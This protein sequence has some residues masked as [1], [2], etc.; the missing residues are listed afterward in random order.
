MQVFLL[1]EGSTLIMHK[2]MVSPRGQFN[3]DALSA[4]VTLNTHCHHL[5]NDERAVHL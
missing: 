1:P 3:Y 2:E 4:K 5:I